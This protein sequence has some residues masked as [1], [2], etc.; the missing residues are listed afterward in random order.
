MTDR[1]VK[2]HKMRTY[3]ELYQE[4][5][6]AMLDGAFLKEIGM[7]KRDMEQEFGKEKW[8]AMA[9]LIQ[10]N[11]E[12]DGRFQA[13]KILPVIRDAV[14]ALAEEPEEGWLRYCYSYTLSRLFPEVNEAFH[15]RDQ[16]RKGRL[17]LL[18]IL[19]GVY[20]YEVLHLAYDPT[21]NMQFLTAAEVEAEG[22]TQ[23]YLKL[24]KMSKSLYLYEFMRIG[25]DI[26]PFNTLG[27]VAGVHYV[28]MHAARQLYAA[29]VPVDLA[30]ISGAA[31]S[32]D[33]GKYGCRKHEEKRIPY[34]HYYYTDLCMNRFG[35][36]VIGHIAANHSTWDLELENLSV[37]SLL[38]IYADFRVKSSRNEKGEE[39]VH[40]YSLADAYDVILGKLDNVDEAKRLRYQK[41]YDKLKDFEDY[42]VELGV[43]T[44]LPA[45]PGMRPKAKPERVKREV[46]LLGGRD[47]VDQLKYSAIEHNI[48]LMSRFHSDTEFASLIETARSEQEMMNLRT[49]ISIFGEYS[50]YMTE[51]QKQLTMKFLY[52]L[53]SHKE[54]DI[55]VQAAQIMG[56][57]VATFSEEYK[58]EVP[59][60]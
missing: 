26:T 2:E 41:V 58:K 48:R 33:I 52:E 19:H 3:N 7:A 55:R 20:R 4:I 43:A 9:A 10:Q 6:Y 54:S 31:A 46:V 59:T 40:F 42:M 13:S 21:K 1:K 44:E 8:H 11:A 32:H 49:Y 30:L 28:A 14:P 16:Y 5:K 12:A 56:H 35:M 37:E 17:W 57:I 25:I 22:F 60:D 24:R 51:K 15:P 18:Q 29:G 34:L 38:L 23:E 53:L 39:I 27:H 47:V 50:T 36:P 45:T